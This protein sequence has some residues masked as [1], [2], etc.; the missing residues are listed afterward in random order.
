VVLVLLLY[1]PRGYIMPKVG[2]KRF[3]YT[4]AGKR[5]ARAYAKK[6]KQRVRRVR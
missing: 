3:P 5:S 4:S 6:A 2:K 1:F